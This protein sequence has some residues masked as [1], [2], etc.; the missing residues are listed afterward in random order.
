MR[1]RP[2][3]V[4]TIDFK[5]DTDGQ[6]TRLHGRQG[7]VEI[8]ATITQAETGRIE[9]VERHQEEIGMHAFTVYRRRNAIAVSHQTRILAPCAKAQRLARFDN[10]RQG[11]LRSEPTPGTHR[12]TYIGLPMNRPAKAT[13]NG[14]GEGFL[15]QTGDPGR[16]K[17]M[18]GIVKC[19]T[20]GNHPLSQFTPP[21]RVILS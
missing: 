5:A 17:S 21:Y 6:R 18:L 14:T 9:P 15:Q 12:C 20:Q 7:P 2:D 10:N 3:A 4:D 1:F 16:Q 13:N 11:G 19:G 8:S